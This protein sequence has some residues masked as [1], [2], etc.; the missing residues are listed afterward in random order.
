MARPTVHVGFLRYRSARWAWVALGLVLASVIL[1]TLPTGGQPPNG[2]TWQGYVLGTVGALLIVW[3]SWLGVR[4]RSY[5]GGV[6]SVQGWVSAHVYLGLALLVVATLHSAGQLGW[7]VHSLAYLLMCGVI[8]SG[9]YGAWAYLDNPGRASRNRLG[10]ARS[11][12]FREL[13]A[14]DRSCRELAGRCDPDVGRAVQSAIARTDLGGGVVH[15][16]LGRDRSRF[17]RRV[18]D[19]A[20]ASSM[21]AVPNGDQAPLVEFLAQRVPRADRRGEAANLQELLAAVCRRQDVLRRLRRDVQLAGWTK[22]WLFLHVP[23]TVG[24]L[25]ALVIH[26]VSTFFYW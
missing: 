24:L 25:G 18:S 3:L 4:K 7:N 21:R 20:G 11:A 23:L 2:G 26:I 8:G 5:R 12:L 14:L 6:G 19:G 17:E 16:L 22:V 9:V 15:Q 1:F 13:Y 10:E